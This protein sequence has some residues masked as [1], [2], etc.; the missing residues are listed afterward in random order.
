VEIVESLLDFVVDGKPLRDWIQEWEGDGQAAE[1]VSL[2]VPSRPQLAVEQIDRLL[3]RRPHQF[4]DRAW[5]LFCN[6]CLD[7]GCY[8]VT[9]DIRRADGK[10]TWSRIGWDNN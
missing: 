8:G 9:T 10:L 1:E 2:L 3:G 7:E 6:I 4:G 5:L